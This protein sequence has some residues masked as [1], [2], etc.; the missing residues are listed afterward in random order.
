MV[1]SEKRARYNEAVEL[2]VFNEFFAKSG[3]IHERFWKDK[4]VI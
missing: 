1:P 3:F 4:Q 2:V